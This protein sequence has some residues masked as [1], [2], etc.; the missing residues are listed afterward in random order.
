MEQIHVVATFLKRNQETTTNEIR[1][2]CAVLPQ[3]PFF[4]PPS[5][6]KMINDMSHERYERSHN[7]CCSFFITEYIS[8]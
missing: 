4:C 7:T 1:I 8:S 6:C 2:E 5:W 3:R